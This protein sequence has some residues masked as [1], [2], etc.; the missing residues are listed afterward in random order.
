MPGA[1]EAPDHWD[2][3]NE[4][5]EVHEDVEGLVNDEEDVWVDALPLDAVVPVGAEG[6]ALCRAGDADG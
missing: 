1:L 6:T 3:Q 5:D 4:D 2:G